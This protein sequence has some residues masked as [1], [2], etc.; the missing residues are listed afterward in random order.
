PR[1]LVRPPYAE[2]RPRADDFLFREDAGGPDRRNYL[3]GTAVYA[4]GAVVVQAFADSGWFADIRGVVPGVRGQGLVT[5]LAVH[6][7][8]TDR[9]GVAPKS[10]TEVMVTEA[11]EKE[12][13]ELGFIALCHCPDTDLA[14]F[15]GNASLQRP[16]AYDRAAG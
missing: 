9:A 13:A 11:R 2:C 14:A 16:A 6:S 15:Y 4:F 1:V 5:G 3:W 8:A 7:F 10:S 12:L